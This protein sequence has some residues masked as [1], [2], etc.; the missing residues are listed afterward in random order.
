M[1]HQECGCSAIIAFH[2]FTPATED[3]QQGGEKL[4]SFTTT[5]LD[6]FHDA[7]KKATHQL[8]AKL[9]NR[10]LL[11][12]VREWRWREVFGPDS[13]S[14]GSRK[15]RYKLPLEKRVADLQWKV[16]HGATATNR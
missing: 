1:K 6:K 2:L 11:E 9:L 13:S 5:S 7:G 14:I 8:L 12:G 16:V 10:R 15:C 4:L 3:W